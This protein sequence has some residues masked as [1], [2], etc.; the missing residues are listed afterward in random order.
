MNWYSYILLYVFAGVVVALLGERGVSAMVGKRFR[1]KPIQ[2][3]VL[4]FIWPWAL[5]MFFLRAF[6][7]T[8]L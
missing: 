7:R 8:R 3:V 4:W 2:V 6:M 5:G 1:F